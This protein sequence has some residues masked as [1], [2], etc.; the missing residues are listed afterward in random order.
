MNNDPREWGFW[1]EVKLDA[2]DRYLTRFTTASQRSPTTLYLD[3]F[4]GSV[5]NV[6]R[7]DNTRHFTGSTVRAIETIPQFTH[8]R[9]FELPQKARQ[10]RNELSARFPNDER[11]AVMEGDCNTTI[12]TTLHDLQAQGLSFAPTL[13]FIDPDGLDVGW[14]TL[15]AL[16][17]FKDRRTRTKPEI[18]I[19]LSH[20]TIP[21]L[22]GW[23]LSMGLDEK[24][25]LSVTR[26]YGTQSWRRIHERRMHHALNASDARSLY[27]A[28]LRYRIQYVLGYSRTL[29]IEMGNERGAPVYVL[30]FATDHEAGVRIM[31]SVFSEAREQSAEYRAEVTER[32]Q[33]DNRQQAGTPTLFDISND[34][35]IMQ[36]LYFE[37]TQIDDAPMLPTWLMKPQGDA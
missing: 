29:T 19:L 26:F 13:C 37:S 34:V 2:L 35:S 5:D 31:S 30:I 17:S 32:R 8:L 16:A 10:L 9:F 23:D 33:R 14:S 36:L 27:T 25:S 20:T 7:D 28:L 1:T 22:A 11:Y 24:L 3:L 18:L 12:S 21:R 6:R 4:A 15:S